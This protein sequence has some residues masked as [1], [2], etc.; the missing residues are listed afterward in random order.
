MNSIRNKIKLREFILITFG[1]FIISASVYFFLL[2]S[3]FTTGSLAGLV[4]VL[5]HFF[6]IPISLMT[7]IINTILLILGFFLVGKEFGIK[8]IYASNLL[9]LFLW[10]F[11]KLYPNV[12]AFTDNIVLSGICVILFTGA[13]LAILFMENA[14]SGGIDIIAMII[15][16][17]FHIDVG[18]AMSLAGVLIVS[19]SIFIYDMENF[20]VSILVTLFMG[21]GID[22]F[23]NGART[24]KRVSIISDNYREIQDYIIHTLNRGCSLYKLEGGYSNEEKIQIVAIVSKREYRYLLNYLGENYSNSFVSVSNVG[25]ISGEWSVGFKKK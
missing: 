20:I 2:P 4:I 12:H 3:G 5:S 9:P 1:G 8:T 18:R 6:P 7:F 11:E 21:N 15:S 24:M 17:Y 22:L 16:K 10:I 25:E 23:I 13:G 19:S 14:S